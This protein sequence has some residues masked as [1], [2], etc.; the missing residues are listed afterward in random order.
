MTRPLMGTLGQ[1]SGEEGCH[2]VPSVVVHLFVFDSHHATV[3]AKRNLT[4]SKGSV[5]CQEPVR[6]VILVDRSWDFRMPSL[7]LPLF[8]PAAGACVEGPAE[9]LAQFLAPPN[10]PGIVARLGQERLV[11]RAPGL[12]VWEGERF[13][14]RNGSVQGRRYMVVDE[15]RTPLA[16]LNIT[17]RTQGR[18]KTAIA[19]N[20]YVR[21]DVRRQGLASALFAQAQSDFPRLVADNSMT[22]DGAALLGRL[23]AP[24][25][26][27]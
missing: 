15:H 19:S 12:E 4:T 5:A 10:D 22:R 3:F 16:C 9:Q 24:R 25:P 23:P 14:V 7:D 21:A 8:D 27:Y 1:V 2:H 6:V 11:H 17:L 18:T 20:V 26:S 13:G